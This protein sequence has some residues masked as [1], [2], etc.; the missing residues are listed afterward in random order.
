MHDLQVYWPRF[1]APA[2]TVSVLQKAGEEPENKGID[3][4]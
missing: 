3:V 4:P 2:S 1:Q